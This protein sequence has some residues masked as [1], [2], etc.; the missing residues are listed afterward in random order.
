MCALLE[1]LEDFV[2]VCL[3]LILMLFWCHIIVLKSSCKHVFLWLSSFFYTLSLPHRGDFLVGVYK[4]CLI[5]HIRMFHSWMM[6]DT[7]PVNQSDLPSRLS[8]YR[9][10]S[11]LQLK[12]VLHHSYGLF[13]TKNFQKYVNCLVAGLYNNTYKVRSHSHVK[14]RVIHSSIKFINRVYSLPGN[15]WVI[16]FYWN[17]WMCVDFLLPNVNQLPRE[18]TEC[19]LISEF[20]KKLY[21]YLVHIYPFLLKK[22]ERLRR[23]VVIFMSWF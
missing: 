8:L 7:P 18:P 9:S 12:F 10:R 3:L 22:D 20:M 11:R 4:C 5:E 13:F 1:F 19:E 21:L 14:Q 17:I 16:L 15:I 2:V 6:E 23:I